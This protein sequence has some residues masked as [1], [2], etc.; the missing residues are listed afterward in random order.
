[1]DP[2]ETLR[3]LRLTIRQMD[4]DENPA[5]KA[6]HAEEVAE[7]F[8]ALDEWLSRGGLLPEAWSPTEKS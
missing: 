8:E 5:I 6:A 2:N 1:M 4:A 3:V 7:Y